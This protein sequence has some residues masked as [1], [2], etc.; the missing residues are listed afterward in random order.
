MAAGSIVSGI[1]HTTLLKRKTAMKAFKIPFFIR[2]VNA[3]FTNVL[4][5]DIFGLKKYK[6]LN[7]G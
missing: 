7:F 3:V 6:K 2:I 4:I 5:A 1:F